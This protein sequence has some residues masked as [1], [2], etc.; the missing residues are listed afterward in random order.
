[1]LHTR[2]RAKGPAHPGEL[3][4]EIFEASNFP[5][6]KADVARALGISRRTLYNLLEGRQAITPE[7]ATRLAAAFGN[8]P[9]FW[10]QLQAEHDLALAWRA[11]RDQL[12]RIPSLLPAAA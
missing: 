2:S 10:L 5:Y 3:L 7:M 6:T 9:R 8:D 12:K 11:L 1:M 4:A